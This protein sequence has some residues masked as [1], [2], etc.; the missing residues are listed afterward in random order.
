MEA[1][2]MYYENTMSYYGC[3]DHY[4]KICLLLMKCCWRAPIILNFPIPPGSPITFVKELHLTRCIFLNAVICN[5]LKCAFL[6]AIWLKLGNQLECRSTGIDARGLN[7]CRYVW[8][9]I[10]VLQMLWTDLVKNLNRCSRT[11]VQIVTYLNQYC[12][13]VIQPM[14][15]FHSCLCF[16][17]SFTQIHLSTFV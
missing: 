17:Y 14:P 9:Y 7:G 3:Y 4:R 15:D 1:M 5:N 6:F 13:E 12:S 10:H 8:P 16:S 2:N 11:G